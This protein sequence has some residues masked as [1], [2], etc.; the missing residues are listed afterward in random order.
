[1]NDVALIDGVDAA[2]VA[3]A[4][5]AVVA[6]PPDAVVAEVDD[7]FELLQPRRPTEATIATDIKAAR[8]RGTDMLVPPY[9]RNE[10]PG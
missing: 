10:M 6:A 3:L 7:F 4:L 2:V 5:D 9:L 8:L 1:M